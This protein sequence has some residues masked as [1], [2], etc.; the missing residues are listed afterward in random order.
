LEKEHQ[1]KA[2]SHLLM[3]QSNLNLDEVKEFSQKAISYSY[4]L[5]KRYALVSP[6]LWHN[7]LV[8]MGIKRRGLCYE[9]AGDLLQYLLKQ[10]YDSLQFYYIGS[11]IGNYFEHNALAVSA[12]GE[13][14]DNSIVLDAWRNSGKLYF[15]EIE[16]DEKYQWK[17]RENLYQ[18]Y[19]QKRW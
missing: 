2:L 14:L 13:G 19:H 1:I 12:R 3:S 15:I 9:W 5:A 8:N 4:T 6:P 16:K 17:N 11:D 18:K 7:S 10:G